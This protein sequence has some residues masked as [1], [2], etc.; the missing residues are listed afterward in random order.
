MVQEAEQTQAAN[1]E[2]QEEEEDVRDDN[3]EITE[4]EKKP[5][6]RKAVSVDERVNATT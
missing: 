2:E 3:K 4:V 5:R 6:N 1:E